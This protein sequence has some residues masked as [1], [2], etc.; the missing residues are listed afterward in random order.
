MTTLAEA[1]V[2]GYQRAVVTCGAYLAGAKVADLSVLG[3]SVTADARRS[4]WRDASLDLAPTEDLDLPAVFALLKTPGIELAIARGVEIADGTQLVAA[5]GRFVPDEPQLKRSGAGYSLSVTASDVS[6]RIQRARW[7]DPYTIA[8]GTP[9]ATAL[10]ELLA[11]RYP[12]VATA[13]TSDVCPDTLGVQVV[14]EAGSDSDPWADAC[15]LASA[16]GYVLC[17]D[18][19]GVVTV[20]RIAPA[21]PGEAVFTFARG[22]TAIITETTLSAT[23]E[24]TYNGVVATGEGTGVDVPVRGE[25]WDDNP[26]SPTYR[27]GPFGR[28]PYFYSSPLLTTADQCETAAAKL[29]AGLLGRVEAFSCQSAVHPGLQPLEV[30]AVEQSDGSS[31][32]YVL[33]AI[34]IPLDL[35]GTMAIT[36]REVL[37]VA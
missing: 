7:V 36:T 37:E 33:D 4:I 1:I 5:L 26:A 25:A 8:S 18:P 21:T 12:L 29:L 15:S 17:P 28:V 10:S 35:G 19:A 34:G 20:R 2:R 3:G 31:R 16:F 6:I 11:D 32:A 30:I 24:R 23:L 9:L 27:L 14:T 22:A 13:I